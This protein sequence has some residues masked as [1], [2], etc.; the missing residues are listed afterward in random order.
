MNSQP[1]KTGVN[2]INILRADVL[3]QSPFAESNCKYRKT[4]LSYKNVAEKMSEI[5]T[6]GNNIHISTFEFQTL[7]IN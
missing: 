4:S 6:P 5:L 2:F 7:N 3:P 1:F